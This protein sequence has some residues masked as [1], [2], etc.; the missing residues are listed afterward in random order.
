MIENSM[1]Y[2]ID[3]LFGFFQS[4]KNT[5]SL[6]SFLTVS[7]HTN[8]STIVCNELMFGEKHTA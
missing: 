4:H 6:L 1:P 2:F 7:I 3:G 8:S 5:H